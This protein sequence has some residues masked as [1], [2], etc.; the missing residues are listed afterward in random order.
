MP[1]A[2][3]TV[4]GAT[5]ARATEVVRVPVKRAGE[6]VVVATAPGRPPQKRKVVVAAGSEV[7]VTLHLAPATAGKR[8]PAARPGAP[9][10]KPTPGDEPGQA[11]GPTGAARPPLKAPRKDD[12]DGTIDPF[13]RPKP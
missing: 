6:H 1:N 5:V 7:E 11:S 10:G 9:A 2:T 3:V 8:K 12:G 4:N 13:K